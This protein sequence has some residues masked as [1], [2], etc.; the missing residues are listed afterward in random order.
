MYCRWGGRDRPKNVRRERCSGAWTSERLRVRFYRL[1]HTT[2][3]WSRPDRPGAVTP[4]GDAA[5]VVSLSKTTRLEL[6]R[7]EPVGGSRNC[8]CR[9]GG[10][11]DPVPGSLARLSRATFIMTNC[12]NH[13]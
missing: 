9:S 13:R 8:T 7:E 2:N 1:D 4:I 11:R 3:R 10:V 5:L 6:L 12:S